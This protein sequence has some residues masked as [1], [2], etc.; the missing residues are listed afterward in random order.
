MA[1]DPAAAYPRFTVTVSLPAPAIGLEALLATICG[2]PAV[3]LPWAKVIG[4]E[5]I[6]SGPQY[7]LDEKDWDKSE[8]KAVPE[9]HRVNTQTIFRGLVKLL[10]PKY[11][12][13]IRERLEVYDFLYG[14]R[15]WHVSS[16]IGSHI[17]QLALFDQLIYG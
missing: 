3:Y 4:M 10:D 14:H 13:P 2:L 11:D 8:P 1:I 9:A 15:H 17:V 7:R 5:V 16:S 12:I 6:P